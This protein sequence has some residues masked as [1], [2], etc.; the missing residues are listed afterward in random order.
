MCVIIC[1]WEPISMRECKWKPT[2]EPAK[3]ENSV[4]SHASAFYENTNLPKLLVSVYHTV[5]G[6]LDSLR[7]LNF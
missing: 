3:V 1:D 4:N 5:C 2:K 7:I 6:F